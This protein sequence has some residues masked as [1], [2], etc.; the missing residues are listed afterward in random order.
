MGGHIGRRGDL[1]LVASN[2]QAVA[3]G[4]QVGLEDVR[5]HVDGRLV[6]SEGVFRPV[7]WGAPV[8]DDNPARCPVRVRSC[9]TGL[10]KHHADHSREEKGTGKN[11]AGT[12]QRE[13][14]NM[15]TSSRRQASQAEHTLIRAK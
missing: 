3:R 11:E 10:G 9:R 14:R 8:A 6:G 4:N 7:P 12:P 13:L 1:V 5:A 2:K 15:G